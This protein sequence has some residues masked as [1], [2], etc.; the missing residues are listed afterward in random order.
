[1]RDDVMAAVEARFL[2]IVT[3]EAPALDPLGL[4]R[5]QGFWAAQTLA[6]GIA[7]DDDPSR[8]LRLL[9]ATERLALA[10]RSAEWM[11]MCPFPEIRAWGRQ[12]VTAVE[13]LIAKGVPFGQS[14]GVEAVGR[15]GKAAG[16]GVKLT[17]RNTLLRRLYAE[18]SEWGALPPR[19]AASAIRAAFMRYER[20]VLPRDYEAGT[21]P[22]DERTRAFFLIMSLGLE[23]AVPGINQLATILQAVRP[24]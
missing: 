22:H 5:D 3:D 4:W 2:M 12:T 21:E 23:V 11:A 16:F 8:V 20:D 1:M 7:A 14:L 13:E 17:C 19:K 6:D 24:I 15:G 9:D 18:D 10:L